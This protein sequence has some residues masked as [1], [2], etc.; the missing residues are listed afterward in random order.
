MSIAPVETDAADAQRRGHLAALAVAEQI[1]W[2]S[3]VLPSGFAVTCYSFAPTPEVEFRFSR[4]AAGVEALARICGVAVS[5]GPHGDDDPRTYVSMTA[6]VDEVSVKAWTLLDAPSD[7]AV[8][9]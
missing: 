1:I 4:S 7:A 8:T 3:P 9:S 6:V 2:T 5:A